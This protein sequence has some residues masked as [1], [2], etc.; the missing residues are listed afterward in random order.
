MELYTFNPEPANCN[1]RW[2]GNSQNK[3][4]YNNVPTSGITPD[5]AKCG[6]INSMLYQQ[7]STGGLSGRGVIPCPFG[8]MSQKENISNTDNYKTILTPITTENISKFRNVNIME[9][10][11]AGF[12]PPQGNFRSLYQIG[13]EWRTG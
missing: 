7:L 6:D 13:Y 8:F 1:N 9:P 5:V 3:N 12:L 10:N 2:C 11:R 4:N